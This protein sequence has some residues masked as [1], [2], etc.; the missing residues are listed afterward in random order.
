MLFL[1]L[2]A[3]AYSTVPNA[4]LPGGWEVHEA[5]SF[6]YV[7]LARPEAGGTELGVALDAKDK[8]KLILSNSSWKL[9]AD[10]NYPLIAGIDGGEKPRKARG[11]SLGS[12]WVALVADI[13]EQSFIDQFAKSSQLGF[14]VRKIAAGTGQGRFETAGAAS[15]AGALQSCQAA[16]KIRVRE[17]AKNKVDRE[18]VFRTDP[19]G[20]HGTNEGLKT[21]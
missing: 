1:S 20:E 19:G 3:A 13:D 12:N 18:T 6:C 21:E 14:E 17:R 7:W 10:R 2:F 8:T 16:L 11:L 9:Q 15:A 5:E 4:A